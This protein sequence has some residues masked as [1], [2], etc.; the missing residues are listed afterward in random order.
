MILWIGL[1]TPWF[2]F[3]C[4]K[5]KDDK[6]Y[7]PQFVLK[8]TDICGKDR[9]S[10]LM[11]IYS[12]P[13]NFARR[14][15]IRRTYANMRE[16]GPM[17]LKRMFIMGLTNKNWILDSKLVQEANIYK[18]I[19]V[20]DFG[21]DY[22]NLSYKGIAAIHF[23]YNYCKNVRYVIKVDDDV[24][25]N[26]PAVMNK[27]HHE[28]AAANFTIWG[29]LFHK[30]RVLHCETVISKWCVS[31]KEYDKFFY[32]SYMVG[33]GYAFLWDI[34]P[35]IHKSSMEIPPFPIDD[36]YITGF[37]LENI[38]NINFVDWRDH[39]ALYNDKAK[40]WLNNPNGKYLYFGHPV[41]TPNM[42]PYWRIM[43][44][45]NSNAWK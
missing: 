28:Y 23:I 42:E 27:L 16:F 38:K 34:V 45:H 4:Y 20:A 26:T 7:H 14:E 5:V 30:N 21:E 29:A 10:T 39:I 2:Y 19:V 37:L 17:G 44:R 12:S 25:V 32:P 41:E 15:A 3:Y 18:D 31:M 40:D 9:N 6:I 24:I 43:L 35:Y 33:V 36:A 13:A 11:Y 22:R 8:Y 1:M